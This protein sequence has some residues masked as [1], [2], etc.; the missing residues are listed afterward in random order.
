M[1]S[2]AKAA[3]VR[4]SN[5]RTE[6]RKRERPAPTFDTSSSHGV[7]GWGIDRR[8]TWALTGYQHWF[9]VPPPLQ[10]P[11]EVKKGNQKGT[12]KLEA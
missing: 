10:A 12:R 6:F 9:H 7:G 2:L 5:M 8:G 11:G 1:N 3:R 4:R